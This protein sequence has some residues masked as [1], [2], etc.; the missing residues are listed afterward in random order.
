LFHDNRYLSFS[1]SKLNLEF[2]F[3]EARTGLFVITLY[4]AKGIRSVDPMGQQ[5][6]YVQLSLG[7]RY[8]KKSK[9]IKGG[10]TDP[11]FTEENILLWADK[12]NWVN[13]LRVELFDEQIGEE[14]VIGLTHFCLLPY[15]NM[16]PN[17][18]KD[19]AFDLFYETLTDPKD[20]KTRKEIPC[21]EIIMRVT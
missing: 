15:M 21:G 16:M 13:D 1:F 17:D 12:D 19:E 11:Y 18:A 8:K 14:K 4:E 9:V 3:E 20:E 10:G 2:C 6:P 5:D 7:K